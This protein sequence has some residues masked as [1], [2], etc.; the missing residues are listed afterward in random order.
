MADIRMTA[1]SA[2]IRTLNPKEFGHPIQS[3]PDTCAV[4]T[5]HRIQCNPD[6]NPLES[7]HFR[8]V[9]G[10]GVRIPWQYGFGRRDAG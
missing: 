1:E 8:V 4:E 2:A 9:F 3:N 7:G 5:G 6:R 10:L